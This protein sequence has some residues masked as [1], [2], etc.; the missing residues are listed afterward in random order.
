M[1]LPNTLFSNIKKLEPGHTLTWKKENGYTIDRY[2]FTA[3]RYKIKKLKM[4]KNIVTE[5]ANKFEE[6]V[7]IRMIGDVPMGAFLSGGLDSSAVVAMMT[8]H[9]KDEVK[10]F[11]IGFDNDNYSELKYAREIADEFGCNH[12]ELIVEPENLINHLPK[13]IKFRD[14][15]VAEPSDIPIYLL[16]KEARK[17][18]KIILTGEGADEILGGYDK[19]YLENYAK[20]YRS[21][22]PELMHK[23]IINPLI[24]SFPYKYHKWKTAINSV[25]IRSDHERYTRWFGA[26]S[27]DDRENLWNGPICKDIGWDEPYFK[28]KGNSRL[29]NILHFDQT[30][31]LPDNLLERGDRMT[32]AASIEARM[33]FMDTELAKFI[34][35]I[36]DKYRVNGMNTKIILRESMKDIL[37]KKVLSRQKVGFKVPV[38]EWFKGELF[39]WLEDHLL[40][41]DSM[42]LKYYNRKKIEEILYEHKNE[43]HNHEKSLWTLLSLEIF[44]KECMT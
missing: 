43:R 27:L 28:D 35:G 24:N 37:P 36:P 30:S 9:Q 22:I 8:R 25:G 3:D 4:S 17:T 33:P 31:W 20:T 6:A 41:D 10:T 5:F 29:R 12:T 18:G 34:S 13:L 15:P 26:F 40:S 32:M 23:K 21:L 7:K 2:F 11:S 42:T 14:A 1:P 16:S 39:D 38:N 44:H 19:H